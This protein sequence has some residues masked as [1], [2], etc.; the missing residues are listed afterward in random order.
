MGFWSILCSAKPHDQGDFCRVKSKVIFRFRRWLSALV[1]PFF[2]PD[3]AKEPSFSNPFF[4]F[5][6]V[7]RSF[8]I[9]FFLLG[10]AVAF[11][12]LG[13]PAVLLIS[14]RYLSD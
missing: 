8:S 5:F 4:T 13:E 11:H 9:H 3:A 7:F 6:M 2:N 1:V 10:K 14:T 12:L